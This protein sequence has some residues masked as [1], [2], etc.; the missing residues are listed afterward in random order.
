MGPLFKLFAAACPTG[1]TA[2]GYNTN[3]PAVCASSD[4]IRPVLQIFFGVIAV[5][6][7]I[8][9]IIAAIRYATALGDP[10]A[11]A[12]LRDTIIFASIGLAVVLSAEAIVTFLLTKI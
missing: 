5:M 12:R 6:T 10:Q 4:T 8:Y 9:I 11:T 1:A 7:V 3:L 2:S